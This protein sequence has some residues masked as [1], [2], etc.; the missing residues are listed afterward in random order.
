MDEV[1]IQDFIRSIK[2]DKNYAFKNIKD[3]TWYY[4]IN[5]Q[6]N[7][8]TITD[9]Y[10]N[11]ERDSSVSEFIDF[12][13]GNGFIVKREYLPIGIDDTHAIVRRE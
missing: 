8:L 4:I 2:Y 5:Y 11:S 3:K 10:Y 6:L 7:Y 13:D 9:F 12:I 1:R